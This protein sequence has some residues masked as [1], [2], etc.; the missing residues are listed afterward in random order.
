[1]SSAKMEHQL[2]LE[3]L[4]NKNQL[5]P[6]IKQEFLECKDF[7][8]VEYMEQNEMPVPFGLDLLVQMILHKRTSLVT[9]VGC[10]R[11]HFNDGQITVDLIQKAAE[12]DMVDYLHDIHTF[13]TRFNLS[14]EVQNE[15]DRFQ[16]PLPM[17]VKPVE[18]TNNRMTGMLTGKGS[19]ILRHNHHDEDVCL[20]H[21]NRVNRMK[22][23]INMSTASMVRN[24]WRNL[25]RVKEGETREEFEKRRKAFDKYDLAARDVMGLLVKEGNQFYLTHRY[26]KRGRIYC[27]GYHVTYQGTPWNKAVIQFAD[28]EI[29]E[30]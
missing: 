16:F 17:V 23:C 28:E 6:R 20:D 13:V 15:L 4:Y 9:L 19:I 27:Q 14:N 7:N 2:E 18:V 3:K 30:G 26:D 12:L 1:M 21:I 22:L 24:Q 29:I 5:I 11:H 25:D 8:F 10:L